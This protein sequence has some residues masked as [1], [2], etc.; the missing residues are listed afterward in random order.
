MLLKELAKEFVFDCRV[1]ELSDKTVKNYQKQV[2]YF[3]DYVEAQ[4]DNSI[5]T[6]QPRPYQR[7]Y[8]WIPV[9]GK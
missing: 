9:K 7:L 5:G 4:H 6:S 3:I 8:Q 2:A 1:R